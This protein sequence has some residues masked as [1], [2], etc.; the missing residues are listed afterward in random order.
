MWD[1][2]NIEHLGRHQV[3]P[4]EAE[5][6]LAGRPLVRRGRD[7]R[8]LVYGPTESGRLLF[9]VCVLK[10]RSVARVLTARSMTDRERSRYRSRQGR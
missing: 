10:D 5:E 1:E 9:M 8:Y 2:E 3:D 7:G 6:V 4:D